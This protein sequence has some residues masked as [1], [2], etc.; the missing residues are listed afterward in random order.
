MHEVSTQL[1]ARARCFFVTK[2]GR[3]GWISLQDKQANMNWVLMSADHCQHN[4]INGEWRQRLT[5]SLKQHRNSNEASVCF[6]SGKKKML[7]C[8]HR[9]T[10]LKD[11]ANC[12]HFRWVYRHLKS[13]WF[14]AQIVQ[15][16][17]GQMNV[18]ADKWKNT[19]QRQKDKHTPE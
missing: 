8:S 3:W 7:Y 18:S 15:V 13:F 17:Q 16:P 12:I 5:H 4:L 10:A 1:W 19:L 11:Q 6:A 2:I 9:S 14:T